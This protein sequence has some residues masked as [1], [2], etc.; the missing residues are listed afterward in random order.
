MFPLLTTPRAPYD[1]SVNRRGDSAGG[2]DQRG[3]GRVISP[4]LIDNTIREGQGGYSRDRLI[5]RDR[6][7]IYVRDYMVGNA[8]TLVDWTN[9]GD[10]RPSLWMRQVT[11]R[12][13]GGTDGTRNFDPRPIQGYGTQ[14]QGHG[15][16]TNPQPFKRA[17][18]ARFQQTAQ[19]QPT[20]F[21]RLSQA[22]YAGQSYSQTTRMAGS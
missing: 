22:R 12:R 5:E 20:S 7:P 17:T 4:G 1:R 19:M 18:N 16:H 11:V 2:A 13:Q 14:D 6:M 3:Q 15:L 9:C 21:N 10:P 8:N